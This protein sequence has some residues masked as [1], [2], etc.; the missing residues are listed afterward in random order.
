MSAQYAV[1]LN[2]SSA[3]AIA[4]EDKFP[5]PFLVGTGP[6]GEKGD[7]GGNIMAIGL[8][9]D[10]S[11][12]SI[13]V[14]TDAVRTSGHTVLGIGIAD[15][16]A[17]AAVN[18]A[19]VT[20]HPRTS[21]ISTN[22]RGFRL[23]VSWRIELDWLGMGLGGDD[24]NAFEELRTL[25]SEVGINAGSG[26]KGGPAFYLATRNYNITRNFS[27]KGCANAWYGTDS[28][29]SSFAEGAGSSII[30][31]S[32][33]SFT[34]ERANTESGTTGTTI[35]A[36]SGENTTFHHIRFAGAGKG[37]GTAPVVIWRGR[38][39]AY[40][41]RFMQGGSHGLSIQATAGSG[42]ATEGNANCWR[43]FDCAFIANGGS[44]LAIGTVAAG[45]VNGGGGF[46]NTFE[47]NG[48]YGIEHAGFLGDR[49][50]ASHFAANTLGHVNQSNSNAVCVFDG[51]YE[52]GVPAS[53]MAGRSYASG[54]GSG[55]AFGTAPT[56]N[57]NN[58]LM[59]FSASEVNGS[60]DVYGSVRMA[61][62]GA[63]FIN[64]QQ[65]VA[66]RFP[67]TPPTAVDLA[68]VC[69]LANF[70]RTAFLTHHGLI[71]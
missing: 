21:F 12:L 11:G 3:I 23:S 40:K 64:S 70:F 13:P 53:T 63:L 37:V 20:A 17:D 25:A 5:T 69:D 38:A 55:A 19:Y 1:L 65:I 26:L 62:G 9:T 61:A 6:R 31:A 36:Y 16:V 15:Y 30:M 42:G 66:E 51:Y 68:T 43:L 32:G 29:L 49:F 57:A 44:G 48:R 52:S 54:P 71:G 22:G 18:L 39:S 59:S 7:P 47:G 56:L 34:V 2:Q 41:C 50:F 24:S 46:G 45:D 67:G 58:G 35:S 33:C 8:F 60:L 10:A 27:W 28:G 14:G 4:R